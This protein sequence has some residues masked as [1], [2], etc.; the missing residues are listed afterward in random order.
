MKENAIGQRIQNLCDEKG[1]TFYRLSAVSGVPASTIRSV[2]KRNNAPT[3]PTLQRLCSALDITLAQFFAEGFDEAE[4]M[5]QEY[6]YEFSRLNSQE[7]A[8]ALAYIRGLLDAK[9][10]QTIKKI[11]GKNSPE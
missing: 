9:E 2:I 1:F 4:T 5:Q 11:S 3:I 8:L 10:I 7:K 6:L